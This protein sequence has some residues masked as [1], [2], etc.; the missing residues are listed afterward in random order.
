[1]QLLNITKQ[2]AALAL[3]EVRAIETAF[4]ALRQ[5][6]P[7]PG[8]YPVNVEAWGDCYRLTISDESGAPLAYLFADQFDL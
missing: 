7:K 8:A 2:G 6:T 3:S 4:D 5:R 1:M